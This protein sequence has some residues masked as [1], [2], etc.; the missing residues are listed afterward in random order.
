MRGEIYLIFKEAINNIAKHS[1]AT[2]VD[3][4][5][6]VTDKTF[7]LNIANNGA[8][9]NIS[10]ISTGQGLNNMKMRAAKAGVSLTVNQVGEMFSIEIKS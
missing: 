5:Y 6:Q 9:G 1:E 3:I 4:R 10:E 2:K 8:T 7:L